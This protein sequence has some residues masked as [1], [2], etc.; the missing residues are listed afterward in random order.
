MKRTS[1][2]RIMPLA[3]LVMVAVPAS[4]QLAPPSIRLSVL[5]S[6][7]GTGE[8]NAPVLLAI[9]AALG[10]ITA[11]AGHR[12][13]HKTSIWKAAARGSLAGTAVFVGKRLI[14]EENPVSW[15]AGRELSAIG[16]SEV[17]NAA[18][19]RAIL[20]RVALPVGPVRIYLSRDSGSFLSAKLDLA[21]VIGSGFL[22]TRREN[23]FGW[24]E[25]LATGAPVFISSTTTAEAGTQSA[26]TITISRFL[27]D[28]FFPG[29]QRK[30][31]VLAHELIHTTQYDFLAL[32]IGNPI[33]E[34]LTRKFRP[35]HQVH[36]YVDFGI[37]VPVQS[38]LNALIPARYRPWEK[39]AGSI[40]SGY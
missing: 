24:R 38:G 19:G 31:G 18:Q 20:S 33:E 1:L 27:P 10:G 35:L 40:S 14:A 15:W 21:T 39:E 30:R 28:G 6:S 17:L 29:F 5:Q 16:S 23:K 9:N 12:G 22:A 11:A 13:S 36:R 34:N 25:S 2:L 3:W 37:L 26:G 8:I 7:R 4:G 32:S